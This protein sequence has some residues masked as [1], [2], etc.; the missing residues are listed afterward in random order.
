MSIAYKKFN[1]DSYVSVEGS[2]ISTVY[3]NLRRSRDRLCVSVAVS[4]GLCNRAASFTYFGEVRPVGQE[5]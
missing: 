2:H 1:T 5:S 3:I 4:V